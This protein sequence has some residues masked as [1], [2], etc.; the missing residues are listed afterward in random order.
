[1][2]C[3]NHAESAIEILSYETL[4]SSMQVIRYKKMK[5]ISWMIETNF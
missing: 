5:A 4:N 1:M 2:K 3:E